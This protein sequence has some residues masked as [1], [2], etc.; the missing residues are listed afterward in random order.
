MKLSDLYTR[1]A[2][3]SGKQ[4]EI[5][6]P[7]GKGSGSFITLLHVDSD[8]FRHKK[9]QVLAKAALFSGEM[10]PEQKRIAQNESMAEIRASLIADWTL[11]DEYSH[12][13]AKELMLNAPYLQDW[14]DKLCD[15][16]NNFLDKGSSDSLST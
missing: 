5:P 2:A 15:D 1:D 10:T 3:N 8:S 9:H 14:V 16:I 6:L 7:D 11:E 12:E 4:F 13:K